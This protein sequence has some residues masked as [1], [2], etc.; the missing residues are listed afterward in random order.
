MGGGKANI[1]GWKLVANGSNT[2]GGAN[3]YTIGTEFR[4]IMNGTS[5]GL[6]AG[7]KAATDPNYKPPELPAPTYQFELPWWFAGSQLGAPPPPPPPPTPTPEPGTLP[8]GVPAAGPFTILAPTDSAFDALLVNLGGAQGRLPLDALLRLPQLKDILL[9][10]IIPGEYTA[11]YLRNNTPVFTSKGVE[12]VPYTDGCM[13]E[14]KL[15]LHDSCIDKPTGDNYTCTEQKS[16]LNPDGSQKCWDPVLTSPISAQWQGGFCQRTCGRCDC[17]PTSGVQ[18]AAVQIADIAA[19]NGVIQSI[20]RVLF[21]PPL[22]TKSQAIQQ[23]IAFNQ[24]LAANMSM[25]IAPAPGMLV[26]GG[27]PGT[28]AVNGSGDAAALP[29]PVTA[30]ASANGTPPAAAGSTEP[31]AAAA[32]VTANGTP[33]AAAGPTEPAGGAA[34][35]AG[36]TGTPPAAAAPTEP[37]AAPP[38]EPA[39]AQ[40]ASNTSAENAAPAPGGPAS[41]P[42]A[43]AGPAQGAPGA[44][45]RLRAIIQ[46]L[47][48]HRPVE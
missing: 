18:C 7:L 16:F 5:T 38:T 31:A 14:G 48:L 46:R 20:S 25:G 36:A 43:P 29:A 47:N 21:P 26:P 22:F 8:V 19:G 44:G 2:T 32:P 28:A 12:V 39:A 3:S 30:A 41:G 42:P 34:T 35:P 9:Y 10:H 37:A 11:Q 45:R 13:T 27:G 15:M 1:T 40:P 24:S 17:S 33:P 6:D 23:A 4:C